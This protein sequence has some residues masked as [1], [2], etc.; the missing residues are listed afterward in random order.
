MVL[1]PEEN[2]CLS[3]RGQEID[4]LLHCARAVH[5]Q[6]DVDQVLRDGLADD[7]PLLV[8]GVLEKLLTQVVAEWV[9]NANRVTK[10]NSESEGKTTCRSSSPR[11]AGRSHGRSCRGVRG[12]LP[13]ASSASSGSHAGPCKDSGFH[14]RGPRAVYP[15]SG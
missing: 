6:R 7:V 15:R 13:R 8:R 1:G 14:R 11:S 4:H 2:T 9:Y 10:P 12:Y 3:T 5:V